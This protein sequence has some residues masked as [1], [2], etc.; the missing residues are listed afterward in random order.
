MKSKKKKKKLDERIEAD[1]RALR[2]DLRQIGTDLAATV[3]S[4]RTRRRVA[5]PAGGKIREV[6]TEMREE[7]ARPGEYEEQPRRRFRILA[8]RRPAASLRALAV[9]FALGTV[10]ALFLLRRRKVYVAEVAP[11]SRWRPRFGWFPVARP[12]RRRNTNRPAARHRKS[13]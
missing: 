7:P 12:S 10:V 4:R 13:G 2:D 1:V 9:F 8:I 6:I 11:P 3:R 5:V